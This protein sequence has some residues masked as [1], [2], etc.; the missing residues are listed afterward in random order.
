MPFFFFLPLDTLLFPIAICF[1]GEEILFNAE[2][3]V[4]Y[5]KKNDIFN[6]IKG[7]EYKDI[8]L[9]QGIIQQEIK[10]TKEYIHYK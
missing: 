4:S 9:I 1:T 2:K 7:V 8:L 5:L 6:S 10:A 3:F